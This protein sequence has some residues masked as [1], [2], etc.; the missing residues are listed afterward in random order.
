VSGLT[1]ES[2]VSFTLT[3]YGH[4]G[5]IK[6]IA[7]PKGYLSMQFRTLKPSKEKK[8]VKVKVAVALASSLNL[9]L[10]PESSTLGSDSPHLPLYTIVESMSSTVTL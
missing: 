7:T 10:P 5:D 9:C 8:P 1:V 4:N 2:S 3:G 6:Y